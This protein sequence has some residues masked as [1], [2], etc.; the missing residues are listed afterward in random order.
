[1]DVGTVGNTIEHGRKSLMSLCMSGAPM[2]HAITFKMEKWAMMRRSRVSVNKN[3]IKDAFHGIS[4][5]LGRGGQCLDDRGDG[6][7]DGWA[8]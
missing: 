3:E 7:F 5:W 4:R 2:V 6:M 8:A 1:M